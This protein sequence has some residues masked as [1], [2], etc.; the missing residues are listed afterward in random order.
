MTPFEIILTIFIGILIILV[1]ILLIMNSR[2]SPSG[3]AST[4]E[5]NDSINR[6]K[7]DINYAM[8]KTINDFNDR[9]E[10]KLSSN[11]KDT[12]ASLYD[13]RLSL[14]KDINT[15]K[16]GLDTKLVGNAKE[17]TTTLS[18]VQANMNKQ[19]NEFIN[20]IEIRLNDQFKAV[21]EKIDQRLVD[22]FKNTD[23]ISKQIIE[24]MAKIDLAQKNI[25]TLSTD[26]VG[27]QSILT[28]NQKRGQFGE[29]QLNQI[30][31]S[32]YGEN[33]KLYE[34]QYTIKEGK[35]EDTKVRADA[36]VKMPPPYNMI[37]I[38]SKFPFTS[39]SKLFADPRPSKEEEI[40]I[41]KE[42][43]L[44]VKK[45]INDISSKYIIHDVTAD[46]ALMFIASD[47]L[48]SILHEKCPELIEYAS[49]KKVIIVSPT[50]IVPLLASFRTININYEQSQNAREIGK[51]L[52]SLADD[53]KRF[54]DRW[55]KLN[56][57]IEKLGEQ[58]TQV[59]TSVNKI[60]SKFNKLKTSDLIE[61]DKD[62]TEEGEN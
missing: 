59:D 42:L 50:I 4:K 51:Q 55:N 47:G 48:L 25:E 9:L 49:D 36:I 30:L 56:D 29:V 28:N 31:F 19:I 33:S 27:L 5:M 2:S 15:F 57:S 16:E 32:C 43:A 35:T 45:H 52:H 21:N 34:I 46:Y 12:T 7:E 1:L 38:D 10:S 44:E 11:T 24:K 40:V 18:E 13:V 37:C 39:Y 54:S 62:K 61:E 23:E 17:M 6:V 41:F 53:F 20:K 58:S 22:G 26:V 3:A 8:S 60:T 14:T